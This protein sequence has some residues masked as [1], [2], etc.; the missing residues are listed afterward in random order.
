MSAVRR[1][2]LLLLVG[3]T[4]L[5]G[6]AVWVGRKPR[7]HAAIE[8]DQ[9]RSPEEWL[10]SEP[11]G[12]LRDYVR[13]DTTE[14]K[15]ERAGAEFLANFF[16]C[17]GIANE[18]VCPAPGRCNLLARLPGKTREGGLLL[19][20]HIDV[21]SYEPTLW[22]EG[23]PFGGE[24]KNGFLYGRGAHDMKSTAIAQAIALRSVRR[25][26]IVPESDI[27]FLAEADEEFG[28]KWGARWLL[29]NRPDWFA[30]VRYVLNE[31]GVN[32]M[33]L[34]DVRYFGVE[35]QQ[36][37]TAWAELDGSD[38]QALG[39]LAARWKKLD[40]GKVA[41]DDQIRA[42]FDLIANHAGYPLNEH[43]RNLDGIR[44]DPE[45]M[46]EVADR[47][48]S[49]LEPRIFW[50]P[51]FPYPFVSPD[52]NRIVL[53]ISTPPGVS[54]VPYLGGILA[55]ATRSGLRAARSFASEPAPASPWAGAD[56]RPTP[57]LS[58]IRDSIEARYPGVP[59]GP[60]PTYGVYTSSVL[61]RRKGFQTYGWTPIAVN[62]TD[63]SRRHAND[64]RVF[65]SDF[66]VG[67]EMY[68]DFLAAFALRPEHEMSVSAIKP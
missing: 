26:G 15:G 36:T 51:V 68:E 4:I 67:V 14:A 23:T 65:L 37:G 21:Y 57:F 22:K 56:G 3:A 19:L 5:A 44:N 17:A 53:V 41:P 7:P 39:A 9:L 28:Q 38:E 8:L 34:R 66:L 18:I 20:N 49:F 25:L 29:E 32:E 45:R 43:L 33:I 59:F 46:A 6:I 58:L 1:P 31:G 64:E 11:V 54:P 42:A 55:D 61:F 50:S 30:G 2:I 63:A 13:I 35:T 52:R 60:I 40:G 62:I 16:D 27:L 48:G 24:I 12:L 10:Q 47:Y